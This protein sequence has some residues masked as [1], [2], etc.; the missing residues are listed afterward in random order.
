MEKKITLIE[1]LKIQKLINQ[2]KTIDI[3]DNEILSGYNKMIKEV[4]RLGLSTEDIKDWLMAKTSG[5]R[6]KTY[7]LR[8]ENVDFDTLDLEFIQETLKTFSFEG[9]EKAPMDRIHSTFDAHLNK[10]RS[11]G[12]KHVAQEGGSCAVKSVATWIKENFGEKD[13]ALFKQFVSE[14]EIKR[15]ETLLEQEPDPTTREQLET[16]LL[17]GKK[18]LEQRTKKSRRFW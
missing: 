10:P 15:L 1:D 18:A 12:R 7:D 14:R 13:Y 6:F 2:G 17:L 16:A 4:D 9:T 5:T 8:Y 3:N 11:R